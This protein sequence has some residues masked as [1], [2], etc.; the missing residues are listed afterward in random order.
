MKKNEIRYLRT[1][2]LPLL[3]A[4]LLLLTLVSG[5]ASPETYGDD[6][7]TFPD[8][9]SPAT[10]QLKKEIDFLVENS[11]SILKTEKLILSVYPASEFSD[12]VSKIRSVPRE[13]DTVDP[14]YFLSLALKLYPDCRKEDSSGTYFDARTARRRFTEFSDSLSAQN[15]LI[16][17]ASDAASVFRAKFGTADNAEII[18][19][20]EE[21]QQAAEEYARAVVY[22]GENV[23]QW[24][25]RIENLK[26]D[27]DN[28]ANAIK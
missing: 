14:V 11:N 4:L 17:Q 16:E 9:I 19:A 28:A 15:R 12:V 2:T 21:Y 23:D 18:L 25:N 3:F 8:R 7:K 26:I 24:Q 5:C 27:L 13:N 1:K 10:A 20:F 6:E 22:S